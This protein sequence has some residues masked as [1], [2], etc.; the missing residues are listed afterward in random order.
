MLRHELF[1]LYEEYEIQMYAVKRAYCEAHGEQPL[2]KKL[3][4]CT[5]KLS[6]KPLDCFFLKLT[7]LDKIAGTTAQSVS[8]NKEEKDVESEGNSD[9]SANRSTRGCRPQTGSAICVQKSL[10][11]GTAKIVRYTFYNILLS[12][13]GRDLAKQC[14]EI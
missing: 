2:W 6:R 10:V 5:L 12:W 7:W 8:L 3:T 1:L 13:R 14:D 9:A 11:V 4:D